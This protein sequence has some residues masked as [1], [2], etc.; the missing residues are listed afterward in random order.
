MNKKEILLKLKEIDNDSYLLIIKAALNIIS[1]EEK[2]KLISLENEAISYR[3]KL[4]CF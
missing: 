1:I 4:K 3:E 2:N